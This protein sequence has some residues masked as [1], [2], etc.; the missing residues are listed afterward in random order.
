MGG[1]ESE[2]EKREEPEPH[3][4]PMAGFEALSL[5]LDRTPERSDN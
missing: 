2:W 5:G 3:G 1:R 4:Q